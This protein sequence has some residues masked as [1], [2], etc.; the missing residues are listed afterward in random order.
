M[1]RMGQDEDDQ[2]AGLRCDHSK[3][4]FIDLVGRSAEEE[5]NNKSQEATNR[6]QGTRLNVVE[7][8]SHGDGRWVRGQG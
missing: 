6:G 1:C 8:Q 7:P 2:V 4:T 3:S 5:Y